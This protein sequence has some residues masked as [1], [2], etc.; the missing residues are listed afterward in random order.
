MKWI[1][2][3]LRANNRQ[4]PDSYP[5]G[6]ALNLRHRPLR[7]G[8]KHQISNTLEWLHLSGLLDFLRDVKDKSS[9][10]V[11]RLW[12]ERQA[13]SSPWATRHEEWRQKEEVGGATC[14]FTLIVQRWTYEC[15][16]YTNIGLA[17]WLNQVPPQVSQQKLS[18]PRWGHPRKASPWGNIEAQGSL[19]RSWRTNIPYGKQGGKSG[20]FYKL[21]RQEGT[22]SNYRLPPWELV[23]RQGYTWPWGWPT[24]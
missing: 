23:F 5:G 11:R 16:L 17:P 12:C 2:H 19:A 24:S 4:N 15:I 10:A 21:G 14:Y 7:V 9:K 13:P 20:Y 18:H 22:S 3:S 1:G 6:L 8:V